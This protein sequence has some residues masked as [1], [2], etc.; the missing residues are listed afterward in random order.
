VKSVG[1][2]LQK[3]KTLRKIGLEQS[4]ITDKNV[5]LIIDGLENNNTINDIN[6]YN[7]HINNRGLSLIASTLAKNTTVTS[8]NLCANYSSHEGA[9][10]MNLM[11]EKNYSLINVDFN[12]RDKSIDKYIER[13]KLLQWKV[14]YSTIVDICIAMTQFQLPN[15]VLLEIVD[16]FPHWV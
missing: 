10:Y 12:C 11:M 4:C 3:N 9:N 8:I 1:I 6:L 13:N 15:Y 5:K 7:N 14:V 16:W 2:L